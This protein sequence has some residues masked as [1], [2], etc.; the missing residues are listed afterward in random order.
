MKRVRSQKEQSFCKNHRILRSQEK[1]VVL[2]DPMR[3]NGNSCNECATGILPEC[4]MLAVP[5]VPVQRSADP[6]YQADRALA[7]GTLF[8]G[9]DLPFLG[10]VNQDMELSTPMRELMA[11]GFAVHELGLYLDT[12]RND[13]EAEDLF[14]QYNKLY[15]EGVAE[16]ERRYGPLQMT[17]S[18]GP[19]FDWVDD[20]WPWDGTCPQARDHRMPS[21]LK[22]D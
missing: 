13:Q 1:E 7:R 14:R 11:L 5:Y 6:G 19:A 21:S 20:P 10:M 3:N 12:H 9:L 16:Y 22:E 15:S 8:P 18:G 2:L 4:G 17:S